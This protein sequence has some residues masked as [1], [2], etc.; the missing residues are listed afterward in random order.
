MGVENFIIGG[1]ITS[2][3]TNQ[4]DILQKRLVAIAAEL[5]VLEKERSEIE[6]A[7]AVLNKYVISSKT[8]NQGD[9]N[10]KPRPSGTPT[11]YEMVKFVLKDAGQKGL[12]GSEIVERIASRYWPGLVGKQILPS[13]YQFTK[14]GRLKKSKAG[15]FTLISQPESG[16]LLSNTSEVDQDEA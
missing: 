15:Y 8:A 16:E 9:G 11:S 7:I 10:G 6:L 5:S 4:T 1:Y 13:V 2:T 3:M 12:K 14:K